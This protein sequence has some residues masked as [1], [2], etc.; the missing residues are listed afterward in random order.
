[1]VGNGALRDS[2]FARQLQGVWLRSWM[3]LCKVQLNESSYFRQLYDVGEG[4]RTG[5]RINERWRSGDDLLS[6]QLTFDRVNLEYFLSLQAFG[7]LL[8]QMSSIL[9]LLREA[10][11]VG[12]KSEG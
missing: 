12:R 10:Q 9:A 6:S 4:L 7:L 5:A 8:L 1:M 2:W 11:L 3:R